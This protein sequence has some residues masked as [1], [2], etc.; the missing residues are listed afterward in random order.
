MALRPAC[1]T[2]APEA[3]VIVAVPEV[4]LIAAEL[5]EEPPR[6]APETVT[7]EVPPTGLFIF[8]PWRVPITSPC[9]TTVW[10]P[11]AFLV[12]DIPS[13]VDAALPLTA[14][15]VLMW[16]AFWFV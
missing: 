9:A 11:E 14:P 7:V 6:T 3:A 10:S 13:P 2:L 12:T 4:I 5:P 8:I 1:P 15:V 16:T